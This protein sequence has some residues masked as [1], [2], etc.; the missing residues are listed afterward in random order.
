MK[1]QQRFEDIE[2]LIK[3]VKGVKNLTLLDNGMLQQEGKKIGDWDYGL[4]N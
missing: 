4:G 1:K 2:E 3:R